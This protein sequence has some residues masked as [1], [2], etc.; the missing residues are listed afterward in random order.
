MVSGFF[1]TKEDYREVMSLLARRL[2]GWA[3][4][5]SGQLELAAAAR[6]ITR[7]RTWRAT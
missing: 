3:Y 6:S 4:D 2:P 7:S 1:G 5:Y